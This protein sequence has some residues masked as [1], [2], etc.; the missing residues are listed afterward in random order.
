[1]EKSGIFFGRVLK[2][3]NRRAQIV[4]LCVPKLNVLPFA[5]EN[6][7]RR[8]YSMEYMELSSFPDC[9]IGVGRLRNRVY[10]AAGR[11]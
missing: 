6:F 3:Y 10:G 4:L 5:R 8:Q 9:V 11:V 1:M 7:T 2:V